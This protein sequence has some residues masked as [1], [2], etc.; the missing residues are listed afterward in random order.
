MLAPANGAARLVRS[1]A[2][3]VVYHPVDTKD[4]RRAVEQHKTMPPDTRA[5]WDAIAE[6]Y[7][8]E[9]RGTYRKREWG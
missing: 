7:D 9:K 2:T 8:R 3:R 6:G 1:L 5:A 4:G